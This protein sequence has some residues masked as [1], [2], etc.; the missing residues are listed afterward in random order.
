MGSEKSL[1]LGNRFYCIFL[2]LTV[3]LA[4][5]VP[6]LRAADRAD[7]LYRQG[8]FGEAEKAYAQGDMDHPKNI[9]YRYNRGCAAYESGNYQGADA[10]FSSVMRRTDDES[11]RQKAAYNSGNAAFKQGDFES[12]IHYYKTALI[13]DNTNEDARYNLELA[14]RE[15]EKQKKEQQKSS[16]NQQQDQKGQKENKKAQ[17][18]EGRESS[19]KD[20]PQKQDKSESKQD[21]ESKAG[22]QPQADQDKGKEKN[23]PRDLSGKLSPRQDMKQGKETEQPPN[24]DRAGIDKKKAEALL[25]NIQEDPSHILQ[26][27]IPEEK[28]RIG[29][30]KS[31]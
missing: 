13:H 15:R 18:K 9:R 24:E 28:R 14:L 26:F 22:R 19:H 3:L 10:A 6:D 20:Q 2:S 16:E 7:E 12:A 5:F 31:W 25:D 11:I 23:E 30:G 27:Q 29:S 17:K 1:M 21:Q 4:F 8:R